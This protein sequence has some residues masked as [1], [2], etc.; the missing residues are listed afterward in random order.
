[1][2][3]NWHHLATLFYFLCNVWKLRC[4]HV[5]G[6]QTDVS[7][8]NFVSCIFSLA[9]FV[10]WFRNSNNRDWW[11]AKSDRQAPLS[12]QST[13]ECF[14]GWSRT[15]IFSFS[16]FGLFVGVPCDM[17]SFVRISVRKQIDRCVSFEK[18][19][20]FS[21]EPIEY[22]TGGKHTPQPTG[23]VATSFRS[24]NRTRVRSFQ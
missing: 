5:G 21:D 12:D 14:D 11:E 22:L 23:K 6:S 3:L 9:N 4:K 8:R 7:D 2:N 10:L 13:R 24:Q 20:S 1:M 16:I 18:S 19:V 15:S 17:Y